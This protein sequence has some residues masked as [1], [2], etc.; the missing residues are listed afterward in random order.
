M[1]AFNADAITDKNIADIAAYLA[2]LPPASAAPVATTSA[3]PT[4]TAPPSSTTPAPASSTTSAPPALAVPVAGAVHGHAVYM[5]NCAACHGANAQGGIGPSLRGEKNRKDTAAA[6]AWIKN[7]R[8]PM[9]KLYPVALSEKDV[10]DVA[11]YVES[12]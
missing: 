1:P 9:P 12:L 4:S 2:A 8:P 11:A 7:P 5:A 6:I 3:A 10:D